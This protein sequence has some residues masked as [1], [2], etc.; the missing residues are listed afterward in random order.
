MTLPYKAKSLQDILRQRSQSSFI[1]REAQIALFRQNMERAPELRD[2]FIFNVWGQGGVGKSTL[3]RQFRNLAEEMEFATALTSDVETSVTEIMGRVA[4][5]FEQ[6]GHKLSAF[7]ERYKVYRQKKQELETDPEAPKGFSAFVGKA[8]A[9]ASLNVVKQVPVSGAI[10]AFL[11]ED[12][13]SN[14]AS[15]WATYVAKKLTNKDEVRLVQEPIEVLT[16]LF[17]EDL[18]KLA[19]QK[20]LLLIFDVYERTSNYLEHWF[21]E[22]L[23][24]RYGDLPANLMLAIAGRNELDKNRWADW[25]V[26]IARLSLSPFTEEEATQFLTRKGITNPQMIDVILR[27]SGCLP[28][29]VTTLAVST[30]NDPAQIGDP[31]GTAVER[32]LK[33]VDDPKRRQL[34]L[35]AALPRSL[36]RDIIAVLHGEENADELFS[37]LRTM[38]FVEER[39]DGW[40]YHDIA[41]TQ[42]LRYK[43]RTSPKNWAEMQGKLADYY[44]QQRKELKIAE[45]LQWQD[46]AWQIYALSVAYHR[47]CQW[48]QRYLSSISVDEALSIT[49]NE[50][51]ARLLAEIALQAGQDAEG[52]EL[53][54]WGRRFVS[55]FKAYDEERYDEVVASL[56]DFLI[57]HPGIAL[58]WKSLFLGARGFIHRLM[59]RNQDSIRDLNQAVELDPNNAKVVANRG[60]SYHSSGQY[61][62]AL[63]DFSSAAELDQNSAWVLNGRGL[64]Y[65]AIKRY[66]EA[67]Q[68]FDRAIEIDPQY[69]YAFFN[70][71]RIH[72]LMNQH[73][74]ALKDF[75]KAIELDPKYLGAITN[76]GA[77]YHLMERYNDALTDYN[78]AVELEPNNPFPVACR[79]EVHESMQ[80]YIK[81]LQD[82]D[83]A[84]ELEPQYKFTITTRGRL[85]KQL[86]HYEDALRNFNQAIELDPKFDWAITNRGEL[87]LTLKRYKEAIADFDR[88]NEINLNDWCLY[89]R[90]LT[91]QACNKLE[92]AQADFDRALQL[93]Q[94]KYDENPERWHNTFNLA[95][96]HLAAGTLKQSWHFYRDALNRGATVSSIRSA[97]CDLEDFLQVFPK[98]EWAGKAKA[99]L[100]KKGHG[101]EVGS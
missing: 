67:I 96:Y 73:E 101:K 68:D 25:E 92:N 82:Y 6:Q 26:A 89:L 9:K 84:V 59:K 28:L 78:Q 1:G 60:F 21:S 79:G 53:E 39:S 10:T 54:E 33:W 32:F 66:E 41:R 70:R 35:D 46:A 76:R 90:A 23:E 24:E 61:E 49:K 8:I 48:P 99:D 42:M 88:V 36:N 80:L 20:H 12:A 22:V 83:R 98:H 87:L 40:V 44:D 63:K 19:N 5:Q 69:K 30:P 29:L 71:G 75:S 65:L 50:K 17:L 91:Y 74:N 94:Q 11:D 45:N 97:I 85:H 57:K 18:C 7:S 31:S 15:D 72:R 52:S 51:N 81:A 37:W 13:I 38:P 93:A 77:L 27:L 100:E 34:A 64:T 2:Y 4:D 56:T 55:V 47:L 62:Q 95:L 16:P 14:Q 3:L 86:G 58:S 43:H